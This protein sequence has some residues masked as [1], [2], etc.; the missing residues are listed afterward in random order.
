MSDGDKNGPAVMDAAQENPTSLIE[1]SEGGPA[2]LNLAVGPPSPLTGCYLLIVIGEPYSQEHKDIVLQKL[3]KGLLSWNAADCHVNLEEELNTITSLAL[4]GEEGKHGERLIQ[5]ASENLVTE[6]LIHPQTNTFIQCMRNLLSS[7]TRHRHIVHAGYTFTGNGSWILQDGTFSVLDFCDEF[8]Q[9]EV[10]RVLRAYPDTISIDIHCAQLGHWSSLPDKNFTKLCKIR[11]NPVDVLDSGNEKLNAFIEYLS[12]MV[13]AADLNSL[14]ECSDV[15]G[16]I[17][18]SHPTLYVFPGGQGD[19]A[20]FGINGFNMLVDGG[21]AR[22]ACFWDFVRHLDRLDAVLMTR[23]NN[24]NICGM[25]SVI[26]RKSS[27]PVYPQIGH[28]FS[29]IPTNRAISSPDGDKDRN[30]LEIDLI[31]EGS[32]L[33]S[34]LKTI[35]LKPQTCYRDSEPINLYHKVGHG[36]LDMYI[37]SPSKDSKEV[38]EFLQKWHANDQRLFASKDSK[39]FSFPVQNIVSICALLVWQPANPDDNITRILFPGSTPD[40]KIFEGLD[41]IKALE[42]LKHPICSVKTVTPSLSTSTLSKKAL[43]GERIIDSAPLKSLKKPE[44]IEKVEK[45]EKLPD[46]EDNKKSIAQ[47]DNRLIEEQQQ[48]QKSEEQVDNVAVEE[49]VTKAEKKEVKS[50]SKAKTGNAKPINN[51]V[52]AKKVETKKPIE[53]EQTAINDKDKEETDDKEEVETKEVT[54]PEVETK[55]KA[56]VAKTKPNVRSRIDSRPPKSMTTAD[57]KAAATKKE[58]EKDQKSSPTT[59]KKTSDPA[60]LPNGTAIAVKEDKPVEKAKIKSLARL[61]KDSPKTTPAKSTKDANNRKVLEARTVAT[62]STRVT[63][64]STTHEDKKEVKTFE[65]KTVAKRTLKKVGS[66]MKISR[67]DV[68]KSIKSEKNGT[69]DSSLVSTPSEDVQKKITTGVLEADPVKQKELNELKEEQEAVREIEAVFQ[70]DQ[71]KHRSHGIILDHRELHE[72]TT[73]AEEEEEYLIIEKEEPY[74]EDSINEHES[75]KDEGEIQKH[76]RDLDESEKKLKEDSKEKE[77]PEIQKHKEDEDDDNEEKDVLKEEIQVEV[78]EIISSAKEIAISKME[79]STEILQKTEDDISSAKKSETKDEDI[80]EGVK[81]EI[82]PIM[83]E[84]QPEEKFSATS[85][86]TTAPT[87]PED[88]VKDIPPL[89]EIKE[90]LAVEEKY[91]KENTKENEAAPTKLPTVFEPLKGEGKTDFAAQSPHLRE[92]V[93]TPDEVDDMPMHEVVDYQGYVEYGGKKIEKSEEVQSETAHKTVDE[94]TE[95]KETQK[96]DEEPQKAEFEELEK[97]K[98]ENE[99]IIEAVE[100]HEDEKAQEEKEIEATTDEK[101]KP[102]STEIRETHITTVES[103]EVSKNDEK[104][105]DTKKTSYQIEEI[106]YMTIEREDSGLND[107]KEEDEYGTSPPKHAEVDD[108]LSASPSMPPRARTPEDVMKIVSKV[109]EVLKTDKDLEDLVPDFDEKEFERRL[110]YKTFEEQDAAAGETTTVQRMLVTASSEDGGVETEICAQ[111]SINF[112]ASPE[113]VKGTKTPTSSGRSSPEMKTSTSVEEKDKNEILEKETLLNKVH[114][115]PVSRIQKEDMELLNDFRRE[116]TTSFLSEKDFTK[117][118]SSI[119]VEKVTQSRSQSISSNIMELEHD[120]H[121]KVDDGMKTITDETIK[122][123]EK[124]PILDQRKESIV[125]VHK[126]DSR[127]AS[128]ASE[129]SVHDEKE[130]SVKIDDRK[131]SIASLTSEQK[132]EAQ[133]DDSRPAS[134]ASVASEKSTHDEK[135]ILPAVDERKESLVSIQK[136]DSRPASQASVASEKLVHE[137]K[138]ASPK[139]EYRKESVAS[140]QKIDAEKED[141]RPVSQASTHDEKEFPVKSD[142]RK[143]SVASIASEQNKEVQ[144]GDSRPLSQAS[145]ASEKETVPKV[146]DHKLDIEKEDSRPASVTSEKSTHDGKESSM[147]TDDRKESIDSLKESEDKKEFSRPDSPASVSSQFSDT[148]KDSKHEEHVADINIRRKS[149]VS[150]ASD[151]AGVIEEHFSRPETP[152]ST[153]CDKEEEIQ[154]KKSTKHDQKPEDRKES[155]VSLQKD[156]SRPLSQASHVSEKSVHDEKDSTDKPGDRKESVASIQKSYIQ[157]ENSRP[158]SAEKKDESRPLSQASHVSEKSVHDEKDEPIKLEDRKESIA[159][160]QKEGSRPLS[161]TSHV[162]EKSTHDEKESTIIPEDRKESVTSVISEQKLDI[163][164]EDSRPPSQASVVSERSTHDEK[165]IP[166]AQD[167]K[168]SVASEHKFEAQK[169][170]SRPLSQASEKSIHDDKESPMITDDRKELIDSLKDAQSKK[171]ASRRPESQASMTSHKSVHDEE[172]TIK[173]KRKESVGSVTAEK[174]LDIQKDDSRP[175]SQA[176]EK[177]THDESSSKIKEETI[178]SNKDLDFKKEDSRPLSQASVISEKSAHEEIPENIDDRKESIISLTT[179]KKDRSRPSS[180]A[181]ATSEKLVH[182]DKEIPA[183]LEDQK[184]S[185]QKLDTQKEDSRPASQASIISEKSIH[186]EKEILPVLDERKESIVSLSSEKKEDVH[187]ES[188]RLANSVNEKSVLDENE[189]KVEKG[190][191][192]PASQISEKSNHDEKDSTVPP[193]D[194]KESIISLTSEKKEESRPLSQASAVSESSAHEEQ[195]LLGKTEERKES[196]VSV[197]KEYS[198]PASQASEKSVHDEKESPV[199]IDDRK[200]QSLH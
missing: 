13:Y 38:K 181:S 69:T 70:K 177:S 174:T 67:K 167:R 190:S 57:R 84:S 148:A 166:K 76:Q 105:A 116:S 88:E 192:G 60:K 127:P 173:E 16:N 21:F 68:K 14:L 156:E 141:S 86:A 3:L 179:E 2:S 128:Q 66:P 168:E 93:K 149:S 118:E 9:N 193:D 87:M 18:F 47:P 111:G 33:V 124:S 106:K 92:I 142:D 50:V 134:Q 58:Q 157:K 94:E 6:V 130:S 95:I 125:S 97:D 53:T 89:D 122:E 155:I 31:E 120:E 41:K 23:L 160:V 135:V 24:S 44:R 197:H 52:D 138:D 100:T 32:R 123:E 112:T 82:D 140:I 109:A 150:V 107:I 72:S 195:N 101:K 133:K 34:N 28:F 114:D 178:I 7:F 27:A 10:Q 186:D 170:D 108:K 17:R 96:V 36:T 165:E 73:E 102:F 85:G 117:E 54:E 91:I 129:K 131:E 8:L 35:N 42:F 63:K 64:Q 22:K 5:Y 49:T 61:Q 158:A 191:L 144:K 187:K 180:Q 104:S 164:K 40:S 154:V 99:Q 62:A 1:T 48:E 121:E 79:T 25:S 39:E 171:E 152:L 26:E 175:M 4:E 162:S 55:P 189:I 159:S 78:Q 71:E 30:P 65:K 136:D 143:E 176:S 137:E 115:T 15:V 182:D 184:E 81:D 29:N 56:K 194:R 43:K 59:P 74:T 185:V 139:I 12:S 169:E 19:A 80:K 20:L 153:E 98:V 146:E 37:I 113:K 163:N 75:N 45:P 51:K 161:Q 151:V 110:S 172:T 188:S 196:I 83:I 11:I 77:E 103:P 126:E 198:R 147:I 200:N 119:V 46:L 145:V 90:D 199:K 132:I 183:K